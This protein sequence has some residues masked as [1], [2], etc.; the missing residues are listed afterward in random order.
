MWLDPIITALLRSPL[1]W[2]LSRRFVL[3]R[4]TGR[5]SGRAF[6]LPV[7]Y[8]R[9]TDREG[10]TLLFFSHRERRWWRNLQG[11]APVKVL[12]AGRWVSGSGDVVNG[13]PDRLTDLF[14]HMYWM[15]PRA[16]AAE[17]AREAILLRIRLAPA[18][19]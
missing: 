11:G 19:R 13:E 18:G 6:T 15:L 16:R 12:L 9:L 8:R 1:H 14:R 17:L 4:V 3:L 2:P 7:F 5:R 10:E